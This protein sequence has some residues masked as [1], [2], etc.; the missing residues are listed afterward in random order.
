MRRY[1]ANDTQNL[2]DAFQ[3]MQDAVDAFHRANTVA[4]QEGARAQFEQATV[5]LLDFALQAVVQ[6]GTAAAFVATG[7]AATGGSATPL[8]II[9]SVAAGDL[10]ASVV[11]DETRYLAEQLAPH[12]S[13]I[14]L[15]L[16]ESVFQ[17]SGSSGDV[18]GPVEL[19]SPIP[20]DPEYAAIFGLTND[21]TQFHIRVE[22]LDGEFRDIRLDLESLTRKLAGSEIIG[23][24]VNADGR[25]VDVSA[26]VGETLDVGRTTTYVS[27]IDGDDEVSITGSGAETIWRVEEGSDALRQARAELKARPS[28][29]LIDGLNLDPIDLSGS[30]H[31]ENLD[32]LLKL[33]TLPNGQGIVISSVAGGEVKAWL[34]V[35]DE[36][37]SAVIRTVSVTSEDAKVGARVALRYN[38]EITVAHDVDF[39]LPPWDVVA[40]AAFSVIGSTIGRQL[41]GGEGLES[42]IAGSVLG[43]ISADIAH[44]LF[45]PPAG[46]ARATAEVFQDL[47]L[48]DQIAIAGVGAVTSYLVGDLINSLGVDGFAGEAMNTLASTAASKIATNIV[49]GAANPFQGAGGGLAGA[50]GSF[51]GAKLAGMV[52]SFDTVGGQLGFSIGSSLGALGA[53]LAF[54]KST[55]IVANFFAPAVGAFVG[56][57]VG[58]LIGSLFGGSPPDPEAGAHVAWKIGPQEFGL[59]KTWSDDWGSPEATE[60]QREVAIAMAENVTDVLNRVFSGGVDGGADVTFDTAEIGQGAYGRYAGDGD[61]QFVFW[62]NG[63][64]NKDNNSLDHSHT[65]RYDV[66]TSENAALDA[67]NHGIRRAL[68]AVTIRGGDLFLKRALYKQ[69]ETTDNPDKNDGTTFDFSALVGDMLTAADLSFMEDNEF[70]VQTAR[71][72]DP[73]SG[74]AYGWL[75]TE[76]R[77]QEL[78]ITDYY[79]SDLYGGLYEFLQEKDVFAGTGLTPADSKLSWGPSNGAARDLYIHDASAALRTDI[80]SGQNSNGMATHDGQTRWHMTH[81][82]FGETVYAMETGQLDGTARGGGASATQKVTIDG[83]KEYEFTVYV[84]G[85]DMGKHDMLFGLSANW[86]GPAYVEEHNGTAWNDQTNPYFTWLAAGSQTN[87]GLDPDKWYR[88]TGYVLPEGVE[89][90]PQRT[91][92]GIYDAMTGERV[93][94]TKTFRWNPTRADDQV[95]ARFFN[96]SGEGNQTW[97][98]YWYGATI[99]ERGGRSQNLIGRS[100]PQA[101]ASAIVV[102]NFAETMGYSGWGTTGGNYNGSV[103]SD[104]KLATGSGGVTMQDSTGINASNGPN[105]AGKSRLSD[106]IYVGTTG[107]DTL[108]GKQG[109]DWLDGGAGNDFVWGHYGNDTVMGGDGHDTVSGELGDDH[110]SGGAGNDLIYG[111]PGNDVLYFDDGI[112]TYDGGSGVDTISF[113]GLNAPLGDVWGVSIYLTSSSSNESGGIAD[114]T[115][116]SVEN[117]IGSSMKDNIVGGGENNDFDGGAGDDRLWGY[118][119]ADTLVG[120]AGADYLNGGSGIDTVSYRTSISGVHVDLLNVDQQGPIIEKGDA[121]GDVYVSIEYVEGSEAADYIRGPDIAGALGHHKFF[122]LGGNDVFGSS[123]GSQIYHGGDGIDTV[124]Y[125]GTSGAVTIDLNVNTAHSGSAGEAKGGDAEG[126]HFDS[127]EQ[128]IGSSGHDVLTGS[129]RSERFSGGPGGDTMRGRGG[130]DSYVL[131]GNDQSNN[132]VSDSSGELDYVLVASVLLGDDFRLVRA[133][134]TD[135]TLRVEGKTADGLESR[136]FLSG[137]FGYG[138]DPKIERLAFE[139]GSFIEISH[140]EQT[141]FGQQDTGTENVNGGATADFLMGGAGN[142]HIIGGGH[143]DILIGGSGADSLYGGDGSD[144]YVYFRGAGWDRIKEGGG[145]SAGYADTLVLAGDIEAQHLVLEYREEGEFIGLHIGVF[146]DGTDLTGLTVDDA[147]DHIF[148][149]NQRSREHAIEKLRIGGQTIDLRRFAG[150]YTGENVAP[151]LRSAAELTSTIENPFNGSVVGSIDAHDSDGDTL[152]YVIIGQSGY[153]AGT[154]SFDGDRLKTTQSWSDQDAK[155]LGYASSSIEFTVSDGVHTVLGQYTVEWVAANLTAA[156]IV[157]DLDGDG[158]E[159]VKSNQSGVTADFDEDGYVDELGWVGADDAFLV[160]DRDASGAIDSLDEIAFVQDREGAE[161]DLEGLRGLD[162]DAHGDS[163]GVL[164]ENDVYFSQ[165][166]VWQDANQNGVSEAEELRSLTDLGIVSI[167]LIGEP[168]GEEIKNTKKNAILNT[169]S[170]LL[171]DGSTMTFGDVVLGVRFGKAKED[172]DAHREELLTRTQM[173][174][175]LKKELPKE[176]RGS[177]ESGSAAPIVL[178]LDGNGIDLQ[179]VGSSTVEFDIDGDGALEAVGWVSPGDALLAHDLDGDGLITSGMELSFLSFKEGAETDLEGLAGLDTDGSG[180]IDAGDERF[181]ELLVWRDWNSDG[182]SAPEEMA[183]LEQLGIASLDLDATPA[184]LFEGGNSI[185]GISTFEASGHRGVLGDVSLGYVELNAHEDAAQEGATPGNEPVRTIDADGIRNK[186]E[187]WNRMHHGYKAGQPLLTD[188]SPIGGKRSHIYKQ[189]A[190]LGEQEAKLREAMARPLFDELAG[191]QKGRPFAPHHE[192][193]TLALP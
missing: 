58:G 97:S 145:V 25:S 134:D 122:G 47:G 48:G 98:T 162:M 169:G 8:L 185:H 39:E 49:T 29:E 28:Q 151:Q 191:P 175:L 85:H 31:Q 32:H 68:D 113:A 142:E 17:Q 86:D 120:G 126:D 150:D 81:G 7:T 146:A 96:W 1:D 141:T 24:I 33:S 159:L 163:D 168:T 27:N 93:A 5:E 112:D 61:N 50:A 59:D 180:A 106:D 173:D 89:L 111:G 171:A 94:G 30:L 174:K 187:N 123:P 102:P 3:G 62:G 121:D 116:V 46:S 43:T 65:G 178:D 192:L 80:V 158:V 84:R 34:N 78:G 26:D 166:Q 91:Y 44:S 181:K 67:I 182:I 136:M 9:A 115:I 193:V 56:A 38:G 157:I 12:V 73:Q 170:V 172:D 63:E 82:P 16:P 184:S 152:S 70:A 77:G 18:L 147:T 177:G 42:V 72:L 156:P 165:F 101:P 117:V 176:S 41:F 103:Y 4:S 127:I 20:L 92:G 10:V 51:I 60:E 139:N 107:A 75:L 37:G 135:S 14:L 22:D 76:I 104:I 55:A 140:L 88:I 129:D 167:D 36:N 155:S 124:D 190:S 64:H 53:G 23:N 149:E 130:D 45:Q 188:L 148:I 13:D 143:R 2:V 108:K 131:S 19:R 99:N 189:E 11:E 52:K 118:G 100:W 179:T 90:D 137:Q 161:T 35:V 133:N 109:W 119:G 71:A 87:L 125:S 79:K 21:N 83:A 154:F 186:M 114:D 69:L 132:W 110:V 6:G 40:P 138:S 95:H 57:L 54:A 160:L 128:I 66:D 105:Y 153:G 144:Q 15:S 164:D 74:L 183:T